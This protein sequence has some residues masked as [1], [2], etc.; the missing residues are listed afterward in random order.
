MAVALDRERWLGLCDRMEVDEAAE[1]FDAVAAAYA[2]PHRHY[3]TAAHVVE[4]LGVLDESDIDPEHPDEVEV[5]VWMHD[6]VY[7]PAR[8]DNE[9]RSAELAARWLAGCI[10]GPA[11][12]DRVRALIAA[13]D[14][15]APTG[16]PDGALVQDVDLHVLGSPE[17]RYAEYERQIRAEYRFVPA[18]IFRR[19]RAAVLSGFLARQP[20]YATEWFRGRFEERART[21]LTAE[22]DRLAG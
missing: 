1:R 3:H 9:E 20:L 12:A 11:A 10:G 22:L 18:V 13:T 21:N 8:G 7:R 4:C 5:A 19:R 17:K 2:E 6:V 15:A 16:D 14:H